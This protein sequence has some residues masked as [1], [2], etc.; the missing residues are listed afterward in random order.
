MPWVYLLLALGALALALLTKST[1][2][3]VASLLVALVLF[4]LWVL[5]LLAGRV[6]ANSR[7]E[8]MMMDPR[9][10]QRLR[11]QAEA[12]RLEQSTARDTPPSPGTE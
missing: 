1:V 3:A 11:E 12:R 10:L 5:G 2:L 7:H 6:D 9:E 8:S 4:L